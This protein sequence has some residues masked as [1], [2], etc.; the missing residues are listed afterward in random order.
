MHGCVIKVAFMVRR[1]MVRSAREREWR[2]ERTEADAR[3]SAVQEIAFRDFVQI[4]AH[5]LSFAYGTARSRK[6][7]ASLSLSFSTITRYLLF[8]FSKEGRASLYSVVYREKT[9]C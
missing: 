1:W 9:E 4:A 3:R 5:V 7:I 6:R 8:S 2:G